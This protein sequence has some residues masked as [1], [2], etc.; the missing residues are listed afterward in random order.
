MVPVR[1]LIYMDSKTAVDRWDN[2]SGYTKVRTSLFRNLGQLGLSFTELMLWLVL[3]SYRFVPTKSG[4]KARNPFI[5]HET[6]GKAMGF[7]PGNRGG[8]RSRY[9]QV[10]RNLE[11]LVKKGWVI[12]F[13]RPGTSSEYDLTPGIEKVLTFESEHQDELGSFLDDET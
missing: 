13:K 1:E 2:D 5:S 10:G 11:A 8:E 9:Q 6:I 12:I 4:Q 7:T 3:L